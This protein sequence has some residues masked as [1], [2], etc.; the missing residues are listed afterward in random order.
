[1][2]TDNLKTEQDNMVLRDNAGKPIRGKR[3]NDIFVDI[4]GRE[5]NPDAYATTLEEARLITKAQ[6]IFVGALQGYLSMSEEELHTDA[7]QAAINADVCDAFKRKRISKRKLTKIAERVAAAGYWSYRAEHLHFILDTVD[8]KPNV[9]QQDTDYLIDSNVE[10]V[11]ERINRD[12]CPAFFATDD[13]RERA[14]AIGIP[15]TVLY[16]PDGELTALQV[17]YKVCVDAESADASEGSN[18]A[19]MRVSNDMISNVLS[20]IGSLALTKRQQAGTRSNPMVQV[21]ASG[22]VKVIVSSTAYND[23]IFLS[24]AADALRDLI[25]NKAYQRGYDSGVV[26][27]TLTEYMEFRNLRDRKEAAKAFATALNDLYCLSVDYYD[28]KT[29]KAV[30]DRILQR[31]EYDPKQGKQTTGTAML[32]SDYRAV[33]SERKT[34]K[35]VPR[36]IYTIPNNK[37]NPYWIAKAFANQL[38]RNISKQDNAGNRLSVEYLLSLTTLPT[39]DSLRDKGQASQRIIKP[40]LEAI[41]YLEDKGILTCIFTYKP[42]AGRGL[43]LTDDD[44]ELMLHDYSLFITLDVEATWHEQPDYSHLIEQKQ[45]RVQERARSSSGKPEGKKRGRPKKVQ[46]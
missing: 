8:G 14:R 40:F 2:G 28:E 22:G 10:G 36:A 32:S 44:I 24:P 42:S 9:R 27:V 38:R 21:T 46:P 20:S 39:Y 17:V 35:Q 30:R 7:V 13:M 37:P 16:I 15:D 1:M 26:E 34:F 29:G 33:L 23:R 41:D 31:I 6:W 5:I 4:K 25:D 43:T 11:I 19:F 12:T 45:K 18:P 3:G